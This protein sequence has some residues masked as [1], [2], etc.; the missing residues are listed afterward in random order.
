MY[1]NAR[2]FEKEVIEYKSAAAVSLAEWAV[3]S[4]RY[5]KVIGRIQP[6]RDELEKTENGLELSK[7]SINKCKQEVVEIDKIVKTLTNT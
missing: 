2:S 7:I 3:T 4:V 5:A 1:K 6:L